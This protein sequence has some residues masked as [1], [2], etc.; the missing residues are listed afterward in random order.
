MNSSRLML[1]AAGLAAGLGRVRVAGA[2]SQVTIGVMETPCV[3]P[4]YV[5]VSQGFLRDEGIDATIVDI[6]MPGNLGLAVD[7][8]NALASG[9]ADVVMNAVWA[10]VPPRTPTGLSVGDLQITAALQRGCMALVV[11]PA[12]PVQSMA[13]LRNQTIAGAKF[14]FGAPLVDA[15]LDPDVDI[16]WAPAPS[17]ANAVPTLQSGDFAAVQTNDAQ[18]VLLQRAGLA[19]MVA[20]N[21]MPPQQS[22]FCCGSI[23]LA[24]NIQ[25]DRPRATAITRALM[26]A[27]VWSEA[28]HDQAAQQ[29]LNVLDTHQDE[30][31][32]ADWQAAM[33]VLAFVPMAEAARPI[34]VDQFDR[35][36][37]YGMPVDQPI[38]AATL[39]DRAYTPLTDEIADAVFQVAS[40]GASSFVCARPTSV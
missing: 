39:V 6:T 25:Q 1:G 8:G 15:G 2:A 27:A 21:D 9:H 23:M 16:S 35:Y 11:P 37:K 36:L 10:A 34:L 33:A 5:A 32:L 7:G 26:R 40:V 3:A 4:A 30:V 14:V 31:S 22:D 18:G 13:D 19:R 17:T 12:S 20:F 28:H 38:D 24:S 29:M